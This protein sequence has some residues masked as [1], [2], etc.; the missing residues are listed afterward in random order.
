[1]NDPSRV[2]TWASF[3]KFEHTLFS[4]PLLY[5]GAVIGGGGFPDPRTAALILGAGTGART[6][7]M[8]LNRIIDRQIDARNPRTMVRELPRGAMKL[9]EAWGIVIVGLLLYLTSCAALSPTALRLSPVPLAAFVLYPY[10]KRLTPLA[11]Y[12][13]GLALSFAPL[14]G[15]VAVT[16]STSNAAAV[17]WLAGFTLLWVAGFDIIYATLDIDFDRGE[18]LQSLPAR[19]GK[20]GSLA[21]AMV[22]HGLA[23]GCL[24]VLYRSHL[25]GVVAVLGI[26]ATAAVLAAEHWMAERVNLAFFKLNIIVGFLVFGLVLAGTLGW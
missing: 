26:I 1:M 8:G 24:V 12:G 10:M 25:S 16:G 6:A 19:L 2:A 21:V 23:V 4:L 14:G 17:L 3:V 13:V 15:F 9:A 22:T 18:G 5:A 7:A 11:H 20:G